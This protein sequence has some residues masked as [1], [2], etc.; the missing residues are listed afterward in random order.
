MEYK[1][2]NTD[3]Y[4]Q[5]MSEYHVGSLTAKAVSAMNYTT[6]EMASFF[7]EK[8][9]PVYRHESLEKIRQILDEALH[10]NRKV[11]I[12]GD[13]DC[14]GIC[15]TTIMVKVLNKLGIENGYYI[16]NRAAENYGL[17][18]ERVRQASERGYQ[19]VLTV[20]NGVSAHEALRLAKDLGMTRIVTDHHIIN[21]DVDCEV[22]CHP[23][24]FAEDYRYL[25]GAGVAY[26]IADYLGLVDDSIKALA[27]LAT[28]SDVMRLKY[29]NVKLVKQGL[30]VVN[31]HRY[32]NI[33]ILGRDLK[34]PV[35][36]RE[37]SFNIAPKVNTTGRLFDLCNPNN[38]VRFFLTDD[39]RTM[40][41]LA[42]QINE[43]NEKR[44]DL[45]TQQYQLIMN[46][47]DFSRPFIIYYNEALHEGLIGLIANKLLYETNKP[48]VILTKSNDV[49]K[50][51][52]RSKSEL[53]LMNL[54]SGYDYYE[55][56]GGHAKAFGISLKPENLAEFEKYIS[57]NYTPEEVTTE[58]LEVE[59]SDLTRE[60]LD[61]LFSYAPFG[62]ARRIPV[63]KVN[64]DG[65]LDFR[66]LSTP[67]KLKWQL[68]EC[69]SA[70][71]M[72]DSRGYEY[73]SGASRLCFYGSLS[74]SVFNRRI[75]YTLWCD[76]VEIL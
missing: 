21:D 14:D 22:L 6:Q 66:T 31:N 8:E 15:A 49:L 29:F 63:L 55:T 26:L 1:V 16:P 56:F 20:D 51:S 12:Y 70:M 42:A 48:T 69:I 23:S 43:L 67:D 75:N 10:N 60:N 39:I 17:N 58:C 18:C 24:L 11:F 46:D 72:N 3:G 52:G 33:D 13:Y 30:E 44:K 4:R 50:G 25:C 53:N 19:I 54:L 61:E 59:M 32:P 27:M 45:V 57:E 38:T 74:S 36:E 71:K 35:T 76:S 68:N 28:I 9:Y 40:T 73:Y 64:C 37:I 5:I 41:V 65:Y 47:C 2:I 34:Y 62:E 7:H